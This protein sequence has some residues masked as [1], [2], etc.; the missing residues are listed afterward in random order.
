VG[1]GK[2][3][4]QELHRIEES[5]ARQDGES[6]GLNYAGSSDALRN[7]ADDYTAVVFDPDVRGKTDRFVLVFEKPK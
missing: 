5:F 1:T 7:S 6:Y 4:A 3:S 2:D